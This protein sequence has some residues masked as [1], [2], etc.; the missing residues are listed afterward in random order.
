M[1]N[2]MLNKMLK[3]FKKNLSPTIPMS[4]IPFSPSPEKE[5]SSSENLE[6]P[7]QGKLPQIRRDPVG[8]WISKIAFAES[9]ISHV[10]VWSVKSL[11]RIL[12]VWAIPLG[13][14]ARLKVIAQIHP[15]YRR[16]SAIFTIA[17]PQVCD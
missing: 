8:Y 13:V 17:N 15:L 7:R 14:Q 6:V 12:P 16:Q 11:S 2:V 1:L 3:M 9:G 10:T 5:T 4:I